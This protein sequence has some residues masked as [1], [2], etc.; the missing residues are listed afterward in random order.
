MTCRSSKLLAYAQYS[1]CCMSCK[2]PNVGQIVA[3]H[4]NRQEHGKGMSIKSS[5]AAIA[6]LCDGCHDHYDG[7]KGKLN[8]LECDS[9]FYKAALNTYVWLLETGKLVLA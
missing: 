4:S 2:S 7:R 3:A 6:Y 9:M 1:P 5:D 8:K